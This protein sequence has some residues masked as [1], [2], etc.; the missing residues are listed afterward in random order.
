MSE[1]LSNVNV[2]LKVF[3]VMKTK[4]FCDTMVMFEK[5]TRR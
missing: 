5:E 1:T 4:R 3:I 2:T